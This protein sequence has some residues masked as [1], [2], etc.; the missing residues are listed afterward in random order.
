M[1][2]AVPG[3]LPL[4]VVARSQSNPAVTDMADAQLDIAPSQGLRLL[5]E[6]QHINSDRD[7]NDVVLSL[8][9]KDR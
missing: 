5:G 9:P 3:S 4:A 8:S 2:F 7:F 6:D 1:N